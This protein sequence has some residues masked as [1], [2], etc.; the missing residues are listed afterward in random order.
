MVNAC[1]HS[2]ATIPTP[3]PRGW[4]SARQS[5]S[6]A[7]VAAYD[8]RRDNRVTVARNIAVLNLTP[9]SHESRSG[10]FAAS[11]SLSEPLHV[12]LEL[13]GRYVAAG[14]L[15]SVLG[16]CQLPR[17]RHDYAVAGSHD[18]RDCQFGAHPHWQG[19][20]NAIADRARSRT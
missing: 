19:W 20:R 10:F 18:G 14:Q 3:R 16:F 2:L 15:L 4:H 5:R 8:D 11:K 1:P 7:S 13:F 6:R 12:R 9:E 17:S